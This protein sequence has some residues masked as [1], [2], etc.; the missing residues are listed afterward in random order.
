MTLLITLAAALAVTILWY[1][2]PKARGLKVGLMCYMYWGA[3]IMWLVD[4]IF[5][6]KELGAGYFT[7]ALADMA[8]DS[9]LGLC[10]V[11]LGAIVWLF[12]LLISDPKGV[13]KDALTQ[14]K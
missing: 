9:F 1:L 6:Y 11:M 12:A 8:N 10:A 2:S 13:I 5:E 4:A 14:K 3:G 7:P